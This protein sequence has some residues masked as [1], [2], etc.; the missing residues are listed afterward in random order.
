MRIGMV[1]AVYKPV[2]NG[3]TRM[4]SLYRQHLEAAGHEVYIFTLGEPHPEDEERVI[5]SPGYM[6]GDYG[7]LLTIRYTREAQRLMQQM[8]VIH[9]HHLFMSVELAHRY[10]RCPIVYTNHTRYDLYAGAYTSLPRS[11][12]DAIMRQVWP[13]FTDYADVVVAPSASVGQIMQEFGV[14][15]P[16]EVIEN[17]VELR[18]FLQPSR[19]LAKADL[20]IP[21]T[22]VLLTYVGRLSPEKNL[23]V[24]LPQFTIARDIVPDLRLMLVG[25]G[26]MQESLE[27]QAQDL[28]IDDAVHFTGAI[29]FEDVPN[30]MAAADLFVTASVTEVHPLTVIEA[31]AAGLPIVAV[32]SPGIVDTVTSGETGLLTTH[33][34]GGLAAAMVGL[35]L[36]PAQR[37]IMSGNAVEASRHYAI[38]DTVARTLALYEKLR[39]ERPDLQRDKPHGLR[40]YNRG[41]LQ[42]VA[43][44]LGR[45]LR[46]SDKPASSRRWIPDSL[47]RRQNNHHDQWHG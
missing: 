21:E 28:G 36:N 5:R 18:P 40:W 38:E 11:A 2:I 17:G 13:E 30:Y 6:V 20:G 10:G 43:N 41:K 27:T 22:A 16:I 44:K 19:P 3:V 33:L 45:W 37:H 26:V 9:S 39:R 23:D 1:T 34:E 15:R 25:K 46:P 24:L 35:A 29:P 8:D 4:V 7:Y 32:S 31:M 14:R 42:P 47:M 12:S